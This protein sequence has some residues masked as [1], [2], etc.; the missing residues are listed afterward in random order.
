M[1][2]EF[3]GVGGGYRNEPGL[4]DFINIGE[5]KINSNTPQPLVEYIDA[6]LLK[7]I[8]SLMQQVTSLET[9]LIPVTLSGALQNPLVPIGGHREKFVEIS[10]SSEVRLKLKSVESELN[11]LSRRLINL[12]LSL[13]V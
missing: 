10:P 6:A 5:Q 8:E 11:E 7:S 12:T 3:N 9:K 2:Q 4:C 1:N 13:D